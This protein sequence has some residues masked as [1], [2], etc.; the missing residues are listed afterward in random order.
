MEDDF[1]VEVLPVDACLVFP[2]THLRLA[3]YTEAEVEYKVAAAWRHFH[4]LCCATAMPQYI[5]ACDCLT[6]LLEALR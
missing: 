4:A 5:S 6:L 3:N 2:G 1:S